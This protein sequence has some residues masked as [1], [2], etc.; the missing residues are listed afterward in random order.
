MTIILAID[1]LD[2]SLVEEFNC[3]NLMLDH[4]GK[5]DI[6]EFSIPQTVT[7]WSSFATEENK[8]SEV[9]ACGWDGR[10]DVAY[11]RK[12]T[13]FGKFANPYIV[14]LPGYNYGMVFIRY[15]HMV[16][17]KY[18]G[19]NGATYSRNDE[20]PKAKAAL[21]HF[22]DIVFD[23]HNRSK[24]LFYEALRRNHERNHDLILIYVAMT[25]L[26]SHIHLPDKAMMRL[27]YDEA[28]SMAAHV[29]DMEA[30]ILIL[31][32][33]GMVM[34]DHGPAHA[35]DYGYWATNFADL[36]NPKITD[37]ADIITT[38]AGV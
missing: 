24:E 21:Q 10:W 16:W 36:G 22:H 34:K 28:E 8:E 7:L 17:G 37:F 11:H 4:H 33:H 13:F 27:A 14:G 38:R 20:G 26:I 25:D 31:S 35:D 1:A 9:A 6:S 30:D 19:A 32:D 12:E 23:Y 3:V 15:A 29:R 5:T 18:A 2:I